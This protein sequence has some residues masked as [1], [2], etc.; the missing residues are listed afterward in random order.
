MQEPKYDFSRQIYYREAA[1]KTYK[2]L[3]FALSMLIAEMPYSIIC[4]VGFF[5]PIYYIPGFS[6]ETSRA[7]FFF[8][9][10]LVTELFSVTLGQ[11]I[12]ALTPSTFIAVLFN[13]FIIIVFSLFCGVTIPPPQI[14]G[15]WRAWLYQLDP[16]TRLVS[17][18]VTNELSGQPVV[19][20][21]SELNRFTAPPGQTC[22]DYMQSF[23]DNGGAGYIVDNATTTCEYCAYKVG[24]QFYAPFGISYDDH[25]R[26]FGILMAFI[27]SNL[28]LL[29]LGSRYLNYNR[30]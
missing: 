17:S 20:T 4:A 24:E 2:Q 30:R 21:Q 27:G 18:L 3:P 19:C 13:P 9:V 25:W 16:F 26:D 1:S 10:V 28:I 29:F 6:H 23:F 14:P 5:L 12:S 11:M 8:L 15:F 22:G 7:G